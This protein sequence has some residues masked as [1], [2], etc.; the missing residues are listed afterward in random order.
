VATQSGRQYVLKFCDCP[1]CFETIYAAESATAVSAGLEFRWR[2][3]LCDHAFQTV[4]AGEGVA[5]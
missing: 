5:A 3:D 2:C 4:E 1:N